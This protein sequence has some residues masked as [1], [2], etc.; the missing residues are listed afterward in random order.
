MSA[1]ASV[2]GFFKKHTLGQSLIRRNP[3]YYEPAWEA[4]EEIERL[5]LA[6][7][8]AWADRQLA[9]T[10]ELARGTEYGRSVRGGDSLT[11]PASIG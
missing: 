11:R 6:G 2:T 3:F 1:V 8:R 5:D 10:F 4:L 9:R 7:R